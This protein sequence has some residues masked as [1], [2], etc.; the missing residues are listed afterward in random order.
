MCLSFL[1]ALG[2]LLGALGRSWV[3]LGRSLGA[4]WA[5]LGRSWGALGRSW[6]F[7]W[8]CLADWMAIDAGLDVWQ[9]L[10]GARLVPS[11][12]SLGSTAHRPPFSCLIFR[13]PEEFATSAQES[14]LAE[15]GHS[16]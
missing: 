4:L 9:T 7:S 1:G 5:L 16:G 2:A 8:R 13:G 14:H 12:P 3:L 10:R 11:F 6:A 15:G